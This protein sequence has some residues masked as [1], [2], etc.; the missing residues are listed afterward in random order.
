MIHEAMVLEYSGRY[1]ALL[2]WAACDQAPALL[3]PARQPL[4]CPGAW[5]ASRLPR[6]L[7]LA[8]PA[9]SSLKLLVAGGGRRRR[10]RRAIAKLRL[11][12]VPELLSVSFV[13]ALL[14][15][16]RPPSSC[17][18]AVDATF[19][20]LSVLGVEPD[21]AA[22]ASSCSGPPRRAG[23][24]RAPSPWQSI[25]LAGVTAVV[26]HYGRRRTCPTGW[27]ALL[28][29]ARRVSRSRGCSGRMERAVP[30]RARARAAT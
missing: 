17:G 26:A 15:V 22:A 18:D 9:A 28:L 8:L 11:F 16:S 10:S 25:V 20:Q 21:P 19:S 5:R 27:P 2:E 29:V 30:R 3:R 12:R 24:R 4:S 14:A 7:L 1:L 6:R 23:L 13:L